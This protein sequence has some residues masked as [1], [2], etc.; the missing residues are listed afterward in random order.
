MRYVIFI[1]L[2]MFSAS[3]LFAEE[4][5]AIM[6]NTEKW[7][8]R[9]NPSIP[10]SD[11]EILAVQAAAERVTLTRNR[12]TARYYGR[13]ESFEIVTVELAPEAGEEHYIVVGYQV[14]NSLICGE[15]NPFY[16][17]RQKPESEKDAYEAALY[18]YQGKASFGPVIINGKVFVVDYN[19]KCQASVSELI[20]EVKQFPYKFNMCK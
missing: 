11:E 19:G 15:T 1:C 17:V 14:C 20:D 8:T 9:S 6:D 16:T 18:V 13:K 4:S 2:I 12:L 7:I 3:P 5:A 10:A